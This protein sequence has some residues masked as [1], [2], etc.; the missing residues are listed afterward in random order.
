MKAR[1]LL[2]ALS[3]MI[4]DPLRRRKGTAFV[5]LLLN[6]CYIVY[7]TAVAAAHSSAWYGT[8]AGYFI[9]VWLIRGGISFATHRA[10]KRARLRASCPKKYVEFSVRRMRA[11]ISGRGDGGCRHPD[12]DRLLSGQHRNIKHRHQR[13]FCRRKTDIR[14]RAVCP[15]PP[16]APPRRPCHAHPRHDLGADVALVARRFHRRR[17]RKRLYCVGADLRIR[18]RRMRRDAR[19]GRLYDRTRRQRMDKKDV[20]FLL[21]LAASP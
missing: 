14:A 5:S 7:L 1:R 15:R 18:G 19:L 8:L 13:S 12:G 17:L 4:A 6:A 21:R 11:P 10:K 9:S 2:P 3:A 16:D 20:F